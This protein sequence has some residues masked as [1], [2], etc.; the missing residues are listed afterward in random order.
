MKIFRMMGDVGEDDSVM[1]CWYDLPTFD[2]APAHARVPELWVVELGV[3][4]EVPL[5]SGGRPL[6]PMAVAMFTV[7]A[8][9][10]RA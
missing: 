2:L 6:A 7:S 9:L 5:L 4:E 8:M 1:I 10:L 3:E